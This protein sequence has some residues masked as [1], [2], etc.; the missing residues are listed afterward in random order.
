MPVIMYRSNLWPYVDDEGNLTQEGILTLDRREEN[1]I[2]KYEGREM[3]LFLSI[4]FTLGVEAWG[5]IGGGDRWFVQQ[6][7]DGVRAV[8][9]EIWLARNDEMRSKLDLPLDEMVEEIKKASR[10]RIRITDGRVG[11]DPGLPMLVTDVYELRDFY[12]S[13]GAVY[14]GE[15]ATVLPPPAP[16]GG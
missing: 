11:K 15:G 10:D 7:D 4:P 16:R 5:T 1:T 14:E 12:T 13:V 8:A 9:Q 3:V 6:T 2:L